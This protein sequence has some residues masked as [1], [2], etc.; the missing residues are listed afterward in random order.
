MRD[1]YF[2][3]IDVLTKC[4]DLPL[5]AMRLLLA[6]GFYGPA[7]NKLKN[8]N[9]VISWF[10]Q[11]ELPMPALNAYM[12]AATESVGVVLLVL[13]L[14]VRFISLPLIVTMLVAIKTVHWSNG[15]P[16]GDN[17]FEIPLYF[18]LMLFTLLIYGGGNLGVDYF[19]RKK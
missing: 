16:S 8:I 11:M 4:K 13:G 19:L 18:I 1:K 14:G 9:G 2:K 6:Y 15:F 17:G 5:L 12:A 10:E 7:M 3:C